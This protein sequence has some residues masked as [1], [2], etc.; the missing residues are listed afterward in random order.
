MVSAC[1]ASLFFQQVS[2][3]LPLITAG[4]LFL[5]LQLRFMMREGQQGPQRMG[6]L[7][8]NKVHVVRGTGERNIQRVGEKPVDFC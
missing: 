1:P 2:G 6:H 8:L 3:F 4:N 5:Q 7:L